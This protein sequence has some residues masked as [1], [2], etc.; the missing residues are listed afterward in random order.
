M[1]DTADASDLGVFGGEGGMMMARDESNRERSRN[2][3]PPMQV[4][5]IERCT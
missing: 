4:P 5:P 3:I 2:L 1:L